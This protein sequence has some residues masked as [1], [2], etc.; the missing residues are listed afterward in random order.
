MPFVD[1]TTFIELLEKLRSENEADVV[2]AAKDV[3]RRMDEGGVTW[4]QVLVDPDR[5]DD[6]TADA[7][8]DD[9]FA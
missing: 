2:T 3:V 9:D 6:D 8:E 1:R 4:D 5:D 7:D